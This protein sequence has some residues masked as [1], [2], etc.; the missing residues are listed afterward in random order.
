MSLLTFRAVLLRVQAVLHARPD[1]NLYR[2]QHLLREK[3][4]E[5]VALIYHYSAFT[6][7]WDHSCYCE[8]PATVSASKT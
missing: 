3:L 8:T 4:K 1:R 6:A 7:L 2:T 5:N